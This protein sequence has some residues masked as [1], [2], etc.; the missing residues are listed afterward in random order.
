MDDSFNTSE[1][2]LSGNRENARATK[3]GAGI[4]RN[5]VDATATTT[6]T[7]AA[8]AATT[9]APAP[10]TTSASAPA[11]TS[12]TTSATATATAISGDGRNVA[13][14]GS[15][16]GHQSAKLSALSATG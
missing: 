9:S 7:A 4:S 16:T 5:G 6:T 3:K 2:I 8:P 1:I 13:S 14:T 15:R 10:A 11:T 12:A